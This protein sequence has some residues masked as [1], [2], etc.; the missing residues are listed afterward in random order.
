VIGAVTPGQ[1]PVVDAIQE[2]TR[3]TRV[4]LL[5]DRDARR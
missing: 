5:P 2:G 1:M 4:Q 3:I